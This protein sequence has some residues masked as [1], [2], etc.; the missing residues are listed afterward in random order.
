MDRAAAYAEKIA[1]RD[2]P[3]GYG[4][5]CQKAHLEQGGTGPPRKGTGEPRCTSGHFEHKR[6]GY[7]TA[8]TIQGKVTR[9]TNYCAR[10]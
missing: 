7:T 4:V 3:P 6:A 2:V 8:Y 9:I 10:V 1:I 5:L